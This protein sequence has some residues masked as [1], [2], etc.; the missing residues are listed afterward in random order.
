MTFQT[1]LV[2]ISRIFAQRLVRVV[3]RDTAYVPIV[4][5]TLAVKNTVRLKAHVVDFH[6]LQ[7]RKLFRAPMTRRAKLL[8]QLIATQQPGIVNRLRRRFACFDGRDVLPAW[9]MTRLTT[10]AMRKLFKLDL[11]TAEHSCRRVTT[12][13]ARYLVRRQQTPN[14]I[15]QRLRHSARRAD[16]EVERLRLIIKTHEAL[17]E[18]SVALEH[19]SLAHLTLSEGVDE[20]KSERVFPIRHRVR[21]LFTVARDLICV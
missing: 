8:R 10:H 18:L 6:A 4:R 12:K 19:I 16:R 1:S 2:V 20:G 11:R 13:T 21:A 7:Q 5:I 17:V 9:S 3:T 15:S 14:C